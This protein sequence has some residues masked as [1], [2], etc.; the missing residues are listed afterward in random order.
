MN[1]NPERIRPPVFGPGIPAPASGYLDAPPYEDPLSYAEFDVTDALAVNVS[2]NPSTALVELQAVGGMG[3]RYRR[4]TLTD[5]ADCTAL[6]AH[7][8]VQSGRGVLFALK[9]DSVAVSILGKLGDSSVTL[10]EN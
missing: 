1:K 6:N 8:S 5:Q 9:A 4:L 2:L 10:I 3:V 7:G